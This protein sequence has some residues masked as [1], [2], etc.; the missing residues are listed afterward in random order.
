MPVTFQCRYC[1]FT[2]VGEYGAGAGFLPPKG[3][4][5]KNVEVECPRPDCK[6]NYRTTPDRQAL[7]PLAVK[8]PI[9]GTRKEPV[10]R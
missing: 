10:A 1:G 7:K 5:V 8:N 6:A 3:W 2:A 4:I 9:N